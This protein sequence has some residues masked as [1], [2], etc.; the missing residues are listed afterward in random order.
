MLLHLPVLIYPPENFFSIYILVGEETSPSPNGR[1][2]TR[3]RR[4]GPIDISAP[5][6]PA[7]AADDH[8]YTDSCGGSST[9]SGTTALST[10]TAT[11]YYVVSLSLSSFTSTGDGVTGEDKVTMCK[12][13]RDI[14]IYGLRGGC[15]AATISKLQVSWVLRLAQL[16]SAMATI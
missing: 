2:L 1:I 12:H 4:L 9:T 13:I 11:T 7:L 3:N 8:S 14:I 5:A 6:R 15:G 10:S 16:V